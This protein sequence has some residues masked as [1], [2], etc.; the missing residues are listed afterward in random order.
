M[1]VGSRTLML[2]RPGVLCLAC[3]LLL[4]ASPARAQSCT[5][6]PATVAPIAPTSNPKY[7]SYRGKTIALSRHVT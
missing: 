3:A 6:D 7:L 4:S 5:E 1:H 2:V